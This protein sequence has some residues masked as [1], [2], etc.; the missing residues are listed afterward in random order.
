M[1]VREPPLSDAYPA[2]A[3][4]GIAGDREGLLSETVQVGRLRER[5]FSSA[6][7]RFLFV[8]FFEKLVCLH[9]S[10]GIE[11]RLRHLFE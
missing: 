11:Q 10:D 5:P 9:K 6:S 3:D 2:L 7:L 4:V 8:Q 1:S